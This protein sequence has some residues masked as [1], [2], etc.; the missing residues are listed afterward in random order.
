HEITGAGQRLDLAGEDLVEAQVVAAR[1]E[2]RRVGG[3]RDRRQRAPVV[4]VPHDVFGGQ[5]L[6]VRGA[7]AVARKEQRAAPLQRLDVAAGQAGDVVGVVLGHPRRE[8][9]EPGQARPRSLRRRHWVI[10]GSPT[11]RTNAANSD[12]AASIAVPITTKSAPAARAAWACAGRR[13]PPPTN[14]GSPATASR[15][16]RITS[17]GTGR[18]APLPA[19]R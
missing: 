4:A 14:K 13:I 19:S 5:V 9:R 18:S 16:A 2:E 1:G 6:G 11:A 8:R 17:A 12:S 3:E 7:A 15:Q 10:P